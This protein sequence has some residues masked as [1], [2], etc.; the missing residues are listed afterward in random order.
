[1][2]LTFYANHP[3]WSQLSNGGGTRTILL[4]AQA[5][6]DLGHRV[7]VV[8][9][10]DRFTWFKHPKPV[11]AVPKD[12]DVLIAVHIH[13]V[14]LVM[15]E[16]KRR[17]CRMAYWARPYELWTM[18]EHDVFE[19]LRKFRKKGGIIMA[20]SSWPVEE[21]DERGIEAHVQFAGMS[22]EWRYPLDMPAERRWVGCQHSTARRKG[23]KCFKQLHKALAYC[24]DIHWNSFSM[25]KYK[26]PWLKHVRNPAHNQLQDLYWDCDYFFCPNTLEGFYNVGAEAALSGCV[27]VCRDTRRNGMG[28]YACPESTIVFRSVGEAAERIRAGEIP[29]KHHLC[30]E[31]VLKIGTREENMQKMVELLS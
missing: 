19:L 10:K 25:S 8:A 1:M 23:W 15:E 12:T 18:S 27:L 5:L 22:E 7:D 9:T 6:R 2:N 14:P 28:D 24:H 21:L 13:D 3:H 4:S 30:R 26:R 29:P 17:R 11:K 16:A 31:R 20:N